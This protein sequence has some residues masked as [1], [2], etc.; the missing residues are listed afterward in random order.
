[1]SE[2]TLSMNL[3]SPSWW[4]TYAIEFA[5]RE[6]THLAIELICGALIVYLIFSK[7]YKPDAETKLSKKV[8]RFTLLSEFVEDELVELENNRLI[9]L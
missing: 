5:Q 7:E 6:P 9:Y 1:M 8:S 3:L 4:V 2:L